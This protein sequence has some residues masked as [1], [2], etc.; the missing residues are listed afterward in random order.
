MKI[1]K[2]IY[3]DNRKDWKNW[4]RKNHK[5]EKEI[6]LIYYNK[7]SGKSRIPYNDAV[8]EALCYGWI[9]STIKKIDKDRFT[10][11]FTPR[12]KKSELSEMNKERI[13]LLIKSK[14]MT[15]AGLKAVEHLIDDKLEDVEPK[16]SQDIKKAL[17]KDKKV[18]E[19]YEKFPASYKRIRIGWI[20]SARIRQEVFEQR[21]NYF[22]KMTE[23]NKMYGMLK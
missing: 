10:Q 14:K 17:Q 23:K 5:K 22:I 13:R 20:E 12:N 21:L 1:G 6:W 16:L 2:T 3:F 9:D 7:A 4:L 18:W 15:K 8:E 19:N 11:R